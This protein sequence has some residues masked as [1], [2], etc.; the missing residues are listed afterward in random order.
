MLEM[1]GVFAA[2]GLTLLVAYVWGYGDGYK[3]GI[4][5]IQKDRKVWR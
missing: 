5:E 1:L 3:Q 2:M 4:K